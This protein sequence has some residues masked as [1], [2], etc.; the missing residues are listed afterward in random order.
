MGVYELGM[1]HHGLGCPRALLAMGWT[2]MDWCAQGR[3]RLV[4]GCVGHGM[5]R[6]SCAVL[7]MGWPGMGWAD[8]G[9]AWPFVGQATTWDFH[10]LAGHV[11]LW[12]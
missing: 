7:A 3:A 8:R 5:V 2:R 6:P 10:G 11:L 4:M 9:L 12:P 1:A